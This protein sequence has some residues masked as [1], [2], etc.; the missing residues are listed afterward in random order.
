MPRF[1]LRSLFAATAL[2][3]IGVATSVSLYHLIDPFG[4]LAFSSDQWAQGD[5][6]HRARMAR[7][8]V[9][10]YLPVGASRAQVEGLIGPPDKTLSASGPQGSSVRGTQTYSY[11]LGSWSNQ[12]MDDAFVHVHFDAGG[13]L[14]GAEI[15]GY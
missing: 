15:T 9:R 1:S 14:L 13:N 5:L 3:A 4:E 8:L 12:G 2:V 11:Y 10:H 7:D 6:G